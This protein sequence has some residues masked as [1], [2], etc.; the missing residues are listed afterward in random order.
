MAAAVPDGPAAPR[1]PWHP[2]SSPKGCI[3]Q[4][5]QG[6]GMG[7]RGDN[8]TRHQAQTARVAYGDGLG[9]I[10]RSPAST[11]WLRQQGVR[12]LGWGSQE[13]REGDAG[14]PAKVQGSNSSSSS[15]KPAF[16][17]AETLDFL[18]GGGKAPR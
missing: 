3:D 14:D 15:T 4:T 11:A 9:R 8:G 6:E 7:G 1:A 2:Q 16:G 12:C 18:E 5:E 13:R 10:P 17:Q